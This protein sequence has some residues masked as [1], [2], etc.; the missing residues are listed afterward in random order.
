MCRS[1]APPRPSTH[2]AMATIV[3]AFGGEV[4]DVVVDR[5]EEHTYHAKVRIRSGGELLVV[6]MRPSDAFMLAVAFDRPIFITEGV[7]AQVFGGGRP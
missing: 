1:L 6:D 4:E 2:D 7:L 5:L 3:R